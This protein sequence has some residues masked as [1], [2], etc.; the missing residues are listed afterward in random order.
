[1]GAWATTQVAAG[2]SMRDAYNSAVA[3]A[4]AEYGHQE[5]YS[6]AINSKEHG[7][8]PVVLPPRFTF[9]KLLRLLEDYGDA[10]QGVGSA[11]YYVEAW[12]TGGFHGARGAKGKLKKA[13]ADLARAEKRLDRVKRSV[14]AALAPK[15][16]SLAETYHD[17][18]G[19]PLA[20]ELRP[21]EAKRYRAGRDKRRGEKVY[22]FCGYA[23]C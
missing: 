20:V 14:P 21:T 23:P 9:D 8:V 5:G 15:M 13:K 6:G 12:S 3:E 10:Q 4:A 18:W 19:P 2:K 16:D 17:K 22:G 7:F 1:M 11:R